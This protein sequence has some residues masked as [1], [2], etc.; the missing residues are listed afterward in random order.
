MFHHPGVS[1]VAAQAGPPDGL[2]L[3]LSNCDKDDYPPK[4]TNMT[5]EN[6]PMNEDVFLFKRGIFHFPS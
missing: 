4:K 6:Q 2:K 3:C 1:T 5:M